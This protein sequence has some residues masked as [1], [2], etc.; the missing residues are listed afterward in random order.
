MLKLSCK[1]QTYAWGKLGSESIVGRIAQK[2]NQEENKELEQT[3][4]AELWMGDHVNGP[5]KITLSASEHAWLGEPDFIA[6]NEG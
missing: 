1:T 5:S 4:F 2:N 3:P 6:Q